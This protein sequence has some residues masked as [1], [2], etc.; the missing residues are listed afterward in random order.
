MSDGYRVP[1][2]PDGMACFAGAD[3]SVILMRNHELW[4][5]HLGSS[6][7]L[8]DQPRPLEAYEE[9]ATGAVTRVVLDPDS[10]EVRSSNLVL[11]GTY[12]NCAGGISPW[13][14]LSCEET[15]EPAHGFVFLCAP[16]AAQVQSAWR[17]DGYGRFRH[18]AAAVDPRTLIAYLTE[19]QIDAGFYR[20]VPDDP[21][22]PFVGTLQALRVPGEPGL[23]TGLLRTGDWVEIDWVPIAEP[24][25]LDDSVRLQA[26]LQGAAR[27]R[28]TEGLW[29]T[30]HDAFI[31]AT[32]GGP[33]DRGQ[34]FRL[35]L[36]EGGVLEVI[37]EASD[38][39]ELDM[40][41]NVCVSPHGVLFVA[42]DGYD[43]NFLRT[44][45][46]EGKIAPFARNARSQT[47]FAGPCFS[48]DGGTLFVNLQ[49]EGL[50]L[51]IQGPFEEEA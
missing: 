27:F 44:I 43:G 30:E 24:A 45:T 18:E 41:D 5:S 6:Y 16:E 47:E 12:W 14:W 3:G 9:A 22:S 15:V 32:G 37:A 40:P 8:P 23:D 1:G 11:A 49:E 7:F 33:L 26:Q 38:P 17:I 29:L 25:P 19:D 28:R 42:E 20:F 51:A 39:R 34:V 31:C 50:T 21:A 2:R 4:Q 46:P 35:G 10:G 13:G 36:D 48:P